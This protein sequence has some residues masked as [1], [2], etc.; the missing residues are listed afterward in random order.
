MNVCGTTRK[1]VITVTEQ[2][3]ADVIRTPESQD[4]EQAVKAEKARCRE[5]IVTVAQD[6][7]YHVNQLQHLYNAMALV[8]DCFDAD[9]PENRFSLSTFA[10]VVREVA[11]DLEETRQELLERW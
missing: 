8:I 10:P 2:E 5:K 1:R 3:Q 7:L 9:K 4:A 6:L 11:D